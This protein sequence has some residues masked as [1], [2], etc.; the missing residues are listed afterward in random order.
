MAFSQGKEKKG[1][2][3]VTRIYEWKII[4]ICNQVRIVVGG[5]E[6]DA[7]FGWR[8]LLLRKQPATKHVKIDVWEIVKSLGGVK[9]IWGGAELSDNSSKTGAISDELCCEQI[10]IKYLPLT[11]L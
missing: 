4:I 7:V 8:F 1:V 9:A 5:N 6:A 11:L 10:M 2:A 3:V